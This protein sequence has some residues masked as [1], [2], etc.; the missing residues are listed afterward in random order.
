MWNDNLQAKKH[1]KV[2]GAEFRFYS[3]E[4]SSESYSP[5][6]TQNAIDDFDGSVLNMIRELRKFSQTYFKKNNIPL[7]TKSSKLASDFD[8]IL[9]VTGCEP[10]KEGH[11]IQM[12]D[13][14]N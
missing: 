6:G 3:G 14:I 10:L 5:I 1:F 9:Q 4:P 2:M 7:Y 11:K 8:L 12:K 13:T